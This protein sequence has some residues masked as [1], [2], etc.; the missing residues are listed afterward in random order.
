[1]RQYNGSLKRVN[2]TVAKRLY[3]SGVDVLF[4]PCN[5]HPENNFYCLGI[6]ENIQ[7]DGQ[8]N[9]FEQL[10]NAFMYYNCTPETGRYIAF[11]VK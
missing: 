3:N 4:I 7:L 1:M 9:T 10:Y 8:Y 2:K 11:Y 5:L 6:W